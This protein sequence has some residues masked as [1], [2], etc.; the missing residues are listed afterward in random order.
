MCDVFENTRA[1]TGPAR[2]VA[3]AA[4]MAARMAPRVM[5]KPVHEF[6]LGFYARLSAISFGVGAA[7]ELFMIK[8]SFYEKSAPQQQQQPLI[9]R[10]AP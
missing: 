10:P 1:R 9:Y 3:K 6:G 5:K 4:G 8:T 2:A 7:M